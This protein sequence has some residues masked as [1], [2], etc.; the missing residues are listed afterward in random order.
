MN[1]RCREGMYD[2]IL[3]PLDGSELAESPLDYAKELAMRSGAEL[4][5]L[6]VCGP[7][8]C[9]CGPDECHIQP[10]HRVYLE[11]TKNILRE[12]LKKAGSETEQLS[13]VVLAG[14]P[15]YEIL[16]YIEENKVSLIVMATHGRSGLRRWVMGSVAVKIHRCS[17][18]PVRLVRSFQNEKMSTKDWP[19]KRILALLDGSEQAEQ[20]L[21]YVVD[22]AKMS[23]AEVTLLRVC[24]KPFITSDY[25]EAS[26][27]L[28]WEEHVER[29]KSHYH[30]Q[31]RL[32]LEEVENRLKDTG[33]KINLESMLADNV[34]QEI[35]EYTA[36]SNPNLIAM[37]T[38]AQCGLGIWPIG[39]TADKVIHGT[40]NP[41][42]LVRPR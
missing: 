29:V 20:V 17:S 14:D 32:Y 11:H 28:T 27:T 34:A 16:R 10:M 7:E 2:K 36:R 5:L 33:L 38:H 21:P 22:H 25:P 42:L 26:M 39:S 18:A 41:I 24:E 40:S 8:E 13:S 23:E 37:T 1:M 9:N 35:I 30:K 6:H 31:C 4:I 19:E 15:A 12:A 3:V